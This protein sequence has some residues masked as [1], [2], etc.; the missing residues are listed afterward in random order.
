[1]ETSTKHPALDGTVLPLSISQREVWLDQM[2]WPGSSH[3]N[4]GG[5]GLLVGL[6][7]VE[8]CRATLRQ[9]AAETEALRLVPRADGSQI[10]L[11]HYEPEL[12]LVDL[13]EWPEPEQAMRHW[14]QQKMR[15]PF[16]LD[17][18]PPWRF[19]LLRGSD[20]LHGI[21]IQFHHLS[22]DGWGTTQIARRWSELY[23]ARITG[24]TAPANDS[25]VYQGFIEE[26]LAYRQSPQFSLDAGYWLAKLPD[27]PPSLIERRQ[28]RRKQAE[29]PEALIATRRIPWADYKQL[30]EFAA[31]R[32]LKAFTVILTA[33]VAYYA[34]VR[35]RSQIVIGIPSMNRSKRQQGV[36]GMFVGVFPLVISVNS[37]ATANDLMTQINALMREA[38]NHSCYPLSELSRNQPAQRGSHDGLFDVLLSFER[39]AYAVTFGEA[40]LINSR[41]LFSGIARYPL[42]VTVCD[43]NRGDDIELVLEG[44][45]DCF[46]ANELDL[47]GRRFW[48][49]L[50]KLMQSPEQAVSALGVLPPDERRALIYG[51]HE[52]VI[53][54]DHTP[55]FVTLFGQ[56]AVSHPEATALV[57]DDSSMTYGQ[58]DRHVNQLARR[59]L[60]RGVVRGTIVA[61][62]L[63][64]AP[65][66]LVSMLA[67][68]RIGGA[69][70]P[71]DPDAPLARLQGIIRQSESPVL[72]VQARNRERFTSLHRWT[73][74]V[75]EE[76]EVFADTPLTL[77]PVSPEDLAY[78]LFTSGST[79]QPKG[80]MVDHATLSRR[81]AWLSRTYGVD[82]SDRSAQFTHYTFDP[83]LI[84]LCLP[85]I[86]GASI[87]LPPPG[88]QQAK[89]LADFAVRHH[90]T[91]MAFV[92]STLQRYLDALQGRPNSCLRVACCGGEM[93]TPELT[94]RFLRETGARLYNVYGPTETAIFATAWACEPSPENTPLPIGQAIDDTR[95]YV[96]DKFLQL[97]PFGE[98]GEIFIGGRAI[99]RGYLKQAELS[100]EVFLED[101]F[102]A[103][104]RLYRTG[105]HGWIGT[106]GMLHFQGRKDRQVKLRGYRIELGEIEAALLAIENVHR[107]AARL[108]SID[109]I[110]A[111]Y[112]WVV[113]DSECDGN[114]TELYRSL[115]MRLPDY[116]LP[117]GISVLPS[118]PETTS[119]KIDFDALP[120]PHEKIYGAPRRAPD[121]VLEEQLLELYQRVLKKEHLSVTDNFFE[122]GGD[123][124][125]AID[126]LVS[127]EKIVGR[128]VSLY[129]L[130]ENP[131]VENLARALSQNTDVIRPMLHLGGPTGKPPLFLAASGHG[132]LI[133]FQALA[134][135]LDGTFDLFM[136][137]PPE[138]GSV[139]S[140]VELARLYADQISSGGQRGF[141]AG[142]SVG[143]IAA[144]ETAR[145]LQERGIVVR[146]LV[147]IDTVY[148]NALL[149]ASRLWHVSG[150]MIHWLHLQELSMN[151]RR[152]GAMFKDPA[153]VAQIMA[154]KNYV[155]ERY[156]GTTLL[157]KSSGLVNWQRWLFKPWRRVLKDSLTEVE[158]AGL[159][160]SLFEPVNVGALASI[161]ESLTM[162]PAG[163]QA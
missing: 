31:S 40:T 43:F 94:N 11:D 45:S 57:G 111:I 72:L 10:L 99:A 51:L 107:A 24:Q 141:V 62:A 41:Q 150:W 127:V 69:F 108:L 85:L 78:V 67:I 25:R 33:I 156:S 38:L 63:E 75:D 142:F 84:E 82:R 119:G 140:T 114:V 4:I 60:A 17:G 80:V 28:P 53:C 157:I 158:T 65:E 123:S 152:L 124:L 106:D 74:A 136:L 163:R 92:P 2:A 42:S 23:N 126:I 162:S 113:V 137:Q 95:I 73:L 125:D 83:S 36:P 97:L 159:H 34:Q 35:Q 44:S 161:L 115:R 91:I 18:H 138:S 64:R 110:P 96:L 47:L 139:T 3:L 118:L 112:A 145:L 101:P 79:G 151:G 135:A 16:A 55:A 54:H 121:S 133:R 132:D 89:A 29:L 130:S 15:E 58:L 39:Q 8:L 102:C 26:S 76:T 116:M 22:M 56:Q 160:G 88:R 71:L 128:K 148:P 21:T 90:V 87:A 9:L 77:F 144:L 105:D 153:L 66:M 61:M 122:V 46:D 131:T 129:L 30:N 98:C 81:L 120:T 103:N 68:A 13:S 1:M 49:L 37:A 32:G 27:A 7:D 117:A 100:R 6:L 155:P 12:T 147:L 50:S 109:G 154:L 134:S 143:G 104:G 59:L 52:K 86:H 14:W 93:L 19:I 70:L 146:G 20:T 48:H 149:R 5:C